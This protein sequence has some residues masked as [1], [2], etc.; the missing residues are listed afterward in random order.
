[1]KFLLVY[2]FIAF[3][4]HA[5]AIAALNFEDLPPG[6][7]VLAY[8]NGRFIGRGTVQSGGRTGNF[9]HLAPDP[10][11]AVPTEGMQPLA[12]ASSNGTTA[13]H[14][15]GLISSFD[16]MLPT[17]GT[18]MYAPGSVK[19]VTLTAGQ[20]YHFQLRTSYIVKFHSAGGANLDNLIAFE[21]SIGHPSRRLGP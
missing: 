6:T 18:M 17:G 19:R 12:F 2:S 20:W 5:Q 10:D 13:Y 21:T 15:R 4:S 8:P 11:F 7:S 1:M 16:V 3:G 14:S 9:V